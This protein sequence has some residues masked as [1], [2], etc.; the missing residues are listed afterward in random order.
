[1]KTTKRYQRGFTFI[2]LILYVAI[3]TM[4][5]TALV[6]FAWNIIEGGAKSATQ[7][8]VFS[9]ARYISERL[10]YEIRNSTG[11]NSVSSTQISL[12]TNDA[13]TNP[14]VISSSSGA[15]TIKQ[16]AS[17]PVALNTPNASV[18]A[19]TFTD[20]TSGDNAT[21]HI[22]FVFTMK[23]NYPGAIKRQEFNET[24]TIE[25]SAEVRTN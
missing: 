10:K 9:T 16:G 5:L 8:E 2:E 11:I 4:L 20:Y 13:A 7:Q 15:I 23:A 3:V 1:M 6:P 17:S 22:Q 19:F 25:G 21:K 24:T 12:I 18:S 14:T